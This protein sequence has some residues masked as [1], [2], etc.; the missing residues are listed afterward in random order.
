MRYHDIIIEGNILNRVSGVEKEAITIIFQTYARNGFK[1]YLVGGAVRDLLSHRQPKDFDFATNAPLDATKK[2]FPHVIATGEEHGTLTIHLND[3]N[4]EVTRFRRDVATDGRRAVIEPSDD[5]IDDL[6]RRDFSVNSM[7]LT[8]DG[9]LIDPFGGQ[10]DLKR[11]VIKFVGRAAD[12]MD[13]D[14]LRILRYFRFHGRLN[15]EEFFDSATEQAIKEKAV[16]LQKIS[17]ER[18]WMEVSK[19][20][21][22]PNGPLEIKKMCDL[23]VAKNIGLPCRNIAQLRSVYA[24]TKNPI[25]LLCA[26][27][28]TQD[29]VAKLAAHWKLTNEERSL[30]TFLVKYKAQKI[31]LDGMKDLAVRNVPRAWLEQLAHLLNMNGGEAM[32][33]LHWEPP[34]FPVKGQDLLDRGYTPGPELGVT[35]K[36]LHQKWVLSRFSLTKEDL[37]SQIS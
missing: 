15:T 29:E 37:L 28:D 6:K 1:C 7:A 17:G 22:G 26:I 8:F 31:D 3:Q 2:I 18:I 34:I 13:E 14:Y 33:I 25:T 35:L 21:S 9:E 23:S 19:I 24:V 20:I 32:H 4:F 30:A 36:K 27:L 5:L 16:G 11:G 12:R 10:Y